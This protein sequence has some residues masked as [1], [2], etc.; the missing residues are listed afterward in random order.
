MLIP[1]PYQTSPPIIIAAALAAL[2]GNLPLL[3]TVV[4]MVAIR[5]ELAGEHAWVISKRGKR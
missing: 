4:H 2:E 5:D 1:N 3:K